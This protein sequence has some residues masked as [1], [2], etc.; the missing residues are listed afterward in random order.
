VRVISIP[1]AFHHLPSPTTPSSST[2]HVFAW[3]CP[4]TTCYHSWFTPPRY[5]RTLVVSAHSAYM[6]FYST[7]YPPGTPTR[8]RGSVT[9][10]PRR[11]E[12]RSSRHIKKLRKDIITPTEREKGSLFVV[13]RPSPGAFA[14]LSPCNPLSCQFFLYPTAFRRLG[15]RNH[16]RLLVCFLLCS[17]LLRFLVSVCVVSD[18]LAVTHYLYLRATLALNI[19]T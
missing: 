2:V 9:I 16:C 6:V 12:A 8:H 19:S 3:F 17:F 18:L 15:A 13:V 7:R 10:L 11:L 1:P 14:F 5:R 4:S